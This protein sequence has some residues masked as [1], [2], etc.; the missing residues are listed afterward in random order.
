MADPG[1]VS[2]WLD[3]ISLASRSGSGQ[4]SA[5]IDFSIFQINPFMYQLAPLLTVLAVLLAAYSVVIAAIMWPL[6]GVMAGALA[7]GVFIR[8]KRGRLTTL[9]SARWANRG[10]IIGQLEKADTANS[11][12][13]V[14]K[15]LD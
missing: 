11:M 14:R 6:A 10:L 2:R 3:W 1:A 4:Q 5:G 12:P 7:L 9:G 13:S 15:L 8:S